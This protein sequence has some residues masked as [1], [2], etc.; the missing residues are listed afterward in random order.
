MLGVHKSLQPVLIS[1]YSETF[2]MIVVEIKA[3]KNF[4]LIVGY[5]PQDHI[6]V[7]ER[8]PFFATLEE[9]IV[10]A[11]MAGKSVIIQMDANS[12]L[13]KNIIPNDP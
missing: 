8:M 9:E 12:K 4:S 2:E 11:K 6:P 10:S 13:G 1:E 5:G 3:S 7:S